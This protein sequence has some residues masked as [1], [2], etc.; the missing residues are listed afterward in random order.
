MKNDGKTHTYDIKFD[1]EDKIS[2][3]YEKV[4]EAVSLELGTF[5]ILVGGK[6][7]M[8]NKQDP[9]GHR[10][11]T[12]YEG[13]INFHER[14]NIVMKMKGGMGKR[15]RGTKDDGEGPAGKQERLNNL[16]RGI[17]GKLTVLKSDRMVHG[18]AMATQTVA[19]LETMQKEIQAGHETWLE[20]KVSRLNKDALQALSKH[21]AT[22]NQEQLLRGIRNGI[23]GDFVNMVKEREAIFKEM[24]EVSMLLMEAGYVGQ[25]L[26]EHNR[27]R[28]ESFA[29]AVI[30][31]LMAA[32]ANDAA[33]G[34]GMQT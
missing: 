23:M 24:N 30:K 1:M 4:A 22:R 34:T 3:F 6:D 17:M 33:A 31:H 29:E 9:Y 25:Y 11:L 5:R 8:G 27:F 16:F 20:S 21:T 15:G 13:E 28:Q 12:D 26:D 2:N 18:D 7:L 14:L 19:W 32:A 10:P